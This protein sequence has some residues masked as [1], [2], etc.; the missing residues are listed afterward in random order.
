MAKGEAVRKPNNYKEIKPKTSERRWLG[1]RGTKL[2]NFVTAV[3]TM[4]KPFSFRIRS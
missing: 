2:I 1:L 3:A 4:G